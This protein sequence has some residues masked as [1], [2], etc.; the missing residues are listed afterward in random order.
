MLNIEENNILLTKGNTAY[1][2]VTLENKERFLKGDTIILSVK[3]DLGNDTNY[4]LQK[5]KT[6]DSESDE[7]I[8]KIEATDTINMLAMSYYYD[9]QLNRSNGDVYTIVTCDTGIPKRNFKLLERVNL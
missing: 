3:K 8:I 2:T 9:I 6:I 7:I 1:I 5:R 4:I